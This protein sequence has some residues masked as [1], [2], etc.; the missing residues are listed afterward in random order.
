MAGAAALAAQVKAENEKNA[1]EIE[2]AAR[3]DVLKTKAEVG[4]AKLKKI[5]WIQHENQLQCLL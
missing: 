4:A 3:A 2:A 1:A 5:P